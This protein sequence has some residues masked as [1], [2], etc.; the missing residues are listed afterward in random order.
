MRQKFSA[1]IDRSVSGIKSVLSLSAGVWPVKPLR[2]AAAIAVCFSLVCAP[3]VAADSAPPDFSDLSERLLP[4]VVN[5]ATTQ[6]VQ[7]RSGQPIPQFPPGSP[8]EEFFK[9]FLGEA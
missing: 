5:I 8:F 3:A 2:R 7:S 1:N 9:D 4:E 6:E